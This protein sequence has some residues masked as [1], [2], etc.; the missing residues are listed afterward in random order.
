MNYNRL[1]KNIIKLD[2]PKIVFVLE[3]SNQCPMKCKY[4]FY[5]YD[6][7]NKI[8][9]DLD[10]PQ[11]FLFLKKISKH[12]LINIDIQYDGNYF[13]LKK[14]VNKLFENELYSLDLT[15]QSSGCGVDIDF[16]KFISD[17]GISV[18]YS[19]DGF[20]NGL[21]KNS[22]SKSAMDLSNKQ[23][24]SFGIITVVSKENESK[25]FSYFKRLVNLY[26]SNFRGINFNY[27][28]TDNLKL[29][30]NSKTIVS[31]YNK[32][33]DYI[34]KNNLPINFSPYFTSIKRKYFKF[35]ELCDDGGCG[36]YKRIFSIS[37]DGRI[38]GC[39]SLIKTYS[40]AGDISQIRTKLL[41]DVQSIKNKLNCNSCM[42]NTICENFCVGKFKS[43]NENM[44][45]I[46]ELC[47]YNKTVCKAVL[48]ILK[49]EKIAKIFAYKPNRYSVNFISSNLSSK[50]YPLGNNGLWDK[51][52]LFF[53]CFK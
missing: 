5:N 35:A 4:C 45:F 41:F 26:P 19:F 7:R 49:S 9:L 6:L 47:I 50:F 28:Y 22:V 52:I 20:Y 10:N 31:E 1:A 32:I 43:I 2:I 39:D 46:Q 30:P 34:I 51:T 3:L 25:L 36:A 38:F 21:R 44:G 33:Y 18:A 12:K 17:F 11:L 48:K 53:L 15:I 37:C 42:Y 14:F 13:R 16:L 8:E 24:V 29:L 40:P 27:I 23:G